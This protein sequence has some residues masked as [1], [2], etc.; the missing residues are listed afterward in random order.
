MSE[1][2]DRENLLETVPRGFETPKRTRS[3][4]FYLVSCN[5]EIYNKKIRMQYTLNV[6]TRAQPYM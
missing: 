2:R 3:C 6:D 5:R 1:E 4:R